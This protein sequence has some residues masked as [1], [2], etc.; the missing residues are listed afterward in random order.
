MRASFITGILVLFGFVA[1]AGNLVS[2]PNQFSAGTPVVAA[3]V[4]ENFATLVDEVNAAVPVNTIHPKNGAELEQAL[5][6]AAT[7]GTPEYDIVLGP[8]GYE[9]STTAVIASS[10][11]IRGAGTDYK[12]TGNNSRTTIYVGSALPA[13][14][15]VFSVESGRLILEGLTVESS[16]TDAGITCARTTASYGTVVVRDSKITINGSGRAAAT[17]RAIN[18]PDGCFLVIE[19]SELRLSSF[20][21]TEIVV[22]DWPRIERTRFY[23]SNTQNASVALKVSGGGMLRG[24]EITSLSGSTKTGIVFTAGGG[25]L[26]QLLQSKVAWG[27]NSD[28]AIDVVAGPTVALAYNELDG[29]LA[30]GGTYRCIGNYERT[31]TPV[32][33]P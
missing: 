7:A 5:E 24:I 28:T 9:L 11:R 12:V 2:V 31:L 18:A 8:G 20:D 1:L 29:T 17:G 30:G 26:L 16:H 10:V 3:E 6:D 25:G 23:D 33:C 21:S 22:G 4:N 32:T 13:G 19:N 15:A 27:N 14:A